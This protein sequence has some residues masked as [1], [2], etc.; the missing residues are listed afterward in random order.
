LAEAR[1]PTIPKELEIPQ[2][3]GLPKEKPRVNG[4]FLKQ[5]REDVKN[6]QK[7]IEQRRKK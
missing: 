2:D 3:N 5:A 4:K 7:K 6:L 1:K